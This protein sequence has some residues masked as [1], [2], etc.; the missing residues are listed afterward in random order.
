MPKA[1]WYIYR[2]LTRECFSIKHKGI[3]VEWILKDEEPLLIVG[4]FKVN[5]S[6]RD[7]V[8]ATGH[9]TVHAFVTTRQKTMQVF[10]EEEWSGFRM[11]EVTYNPH[12]N[13]TFVYKDT[14][15]VADGNL[16]VLQYPKVYC[17]TP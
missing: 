8:R 6:G 11:R 16:I 14:G 2:N 13:D 12:K 15:E 10:I 9:K 3:V 7:R 17:L 1:Q 4:G 5:A